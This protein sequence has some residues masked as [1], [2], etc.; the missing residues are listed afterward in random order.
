[1]EIAKQHY[2]R[3]VELIQLRDWTAAIHEFREVIR[4]VPRHAGAH[5]HLGDAL[6]GGGDLDNAIAEYRASLEL[7]P[8]DVDASW[9]HYYIGVIEQKKR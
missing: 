8:E 9:A 5:F 1:M 2:E 4:L 7:D 3:G 6:R